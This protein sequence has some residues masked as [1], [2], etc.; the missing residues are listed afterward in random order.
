MARADQVKKEG[1]LAD[2]EPSKSPA[3][4]KKE[5][6]QPSYIAVCFQSRVARR[7]CARGLC[8]HLVY[9]VAPRLIGLP[10]RASFALP[11]P[12]AVPTTGGGGGAA[13]AKQ[14]V[15]APTTSSA[16]C[17]DVFVEVRRTAFFFESFA[18]PCHSTQRLLHACSAPSQPVVAS[19]HQPPAA[20]GSAA[21]SLPL[22]ACRAFEVKARAD[23]EL[24][25]S[26]VFVEVR[27]TASLCFLSALR[28]HAPHPRHSTQ[29]LLHT[30][31]QFPCALGL[32]G[33]LPAR[34]EA[35][36]HLVFG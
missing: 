8:H 14:S 36:A 28:T 12:V 34:F 18:N 15:R 3:N 26:D 31:A 5:K 22:G 13:K 11:P 19:S 23:H 27:R 20:G 7:R 2:V 21:I 29:R 30:R 35:A 24:R 6:K 16:R 25:C 4:K 9:V 1:T 32:S 10:G 33:S 17:S